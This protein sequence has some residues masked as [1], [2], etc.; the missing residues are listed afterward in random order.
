MLLTCAYGRSAFAQLAY[1]AIFTPAP[2]PTFPTPAAR[3]FNAG[4]T[5]EI[6]FSAYLTPNEVIDYAFDWTGDGPLGLEDGEEIL[7]SSWS[8][9]GISVVSPA[10]YIQ[11][12]GTSTTVWLSIGSGFAPGIYEV[13]NL[14]RTSGGRTLECSFV[15][16]VNSENS[17]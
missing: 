2:T 8:A 11:D 17:F 1:A 15:C 9:S 5:P 12:N 14:I 13:T 7:S 3:T 6:R 16:Y 10:P 4:G